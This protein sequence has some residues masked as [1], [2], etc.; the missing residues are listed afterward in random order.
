MSVV[1]ERLI[2]FAFAV[3]LSGT[4]ILVLA[5][6]L[7]RWNA[8]K[9]AA[10]CP[11]GFREELR[12]CLESG[13]V[14]R[15]VDL[16][17]STPGP[18]AGVAGAGIRR[19]LELAPSEDDSAFFCAMAP[20]ELH[21]MESKVNDGM[22]QQGD[23]EL[24]RLEEHLNLLST[25]GSIAPLMGFL[26]TVAGMIIA[27]Q[28]IAGAGMGKPQTVAGGISTALVTTAAGLAIAIP[29]FASHNYFA[30]R[31]KV[32]LEDMNETAATVVRALVTD[33]EDTLTQQE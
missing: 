1:L 32:F 30:N 26:G 3:M 19:Y 22:Q 7:E 13:A 31:V 15:A 10:A 12:Y 23:K 21:R 28:K 29:A 6:I 16:C 17:E 25:L 14:R 33:K 8:Y 27:F 18:T 9:L 5:A 20:S 11:P 4:S 24:S 2:Q